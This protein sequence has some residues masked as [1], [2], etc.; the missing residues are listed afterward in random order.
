MNHYKIVSHLAE[1]IQLY[2]LHNSLNQSGEPDEQLMDYLFGNI[3]RAWPILKEYLNASAVATCEEMF[4]GLY[5]DYE[6]VKMTALTLFG[7]IM[8]EPASYMRTDVWG[9]ARA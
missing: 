2:I 6:G 7:G 4:R 3:Q 9:R 1:S 8:T 5:T